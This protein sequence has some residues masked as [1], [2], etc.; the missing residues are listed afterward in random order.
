MAVKKPRNVRTKAETQAALEGIE[1]LAAQQETPPM[2]EAR[3]VEVRAA[4]K[5]LSVESAVQKV[6]SV[7]LDISRSL[8]AVS[9]QLVEQTRQLAVVKE[10]VAIETAELEQLHGKD[11]IASAMADLLAVIAAKKLEWDAAQ[12]KKMA[13]IAQQDAERQTIRQ[14]EEADYSYNMTLARKKE[15]DDW[16]MASLQRDRAEAL[17]RSDLERNWTERE[18]ALK[19]REA[20][21]AALK[22]RVDNLPEE[23]EKL[24]QT[25]ITET[26][27]SCDASKHFEISHLKKDAEAAAQLANLK[28]TTLGESLAQAHQQ[29]RALG[30]DLASANTQVKSI[31]EKA[32]ESSSGQRALSE[33]TSLMQSR[34]ENGT[35]RSKG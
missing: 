8:A 24:R 12:Q 14:H 21:F 16:A 23:F 34:Q 19:A 22:A 20:E 32:L 11:V 29:I 35:S 27:A 31:A 2:Q 1:R 3:K 15:K 25:T 9:E 18:V 6:T 4:V 10:A 33:V 30:Q 17:R 28:I 13:E 26:K 7:N 5:D